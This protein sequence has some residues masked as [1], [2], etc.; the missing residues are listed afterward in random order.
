MVYFKD[1]NG[2]YQHVNRAL[3]RASLQPGDH[4]VGMTDEDI[5]PAELAAQL[6]QQDL[7][8]IGR[9]EGEDPLEFEGWDALFGNAPRYFNTRKLQ[10]RDREGGVIGTLGITRDD[11]HLKQVKQALSYSQ[12][13]I[14]LS[15]DMMALFDHAG[16][17]LS[18]NRA[19]RQGFLKPSDEIIGKHWKE[20]GQEQAENHPEFE[21]NYIKSLA[22]EIITTSMSLD[23]P[24]LGQCHVNLRYTPFRVDSGEING[25]S[26]TIHDITELD[27]A[28]EGLRRYKKILSATHDL[29]SFVTLDYTFAAVNAAFELFFGFSKNEIIG[30]SIAQFRRDGETFADVKRYYDQCI[31]GDVLEFEQEI[32]SSVTGDTHV[33]E[34]SYY[35]YRDENG[36]ITGVVVSAR[37]VTSRRKTE[38]DLSQYKDI[39]SASLD[40]MAML[41]LDYR[42][43]AINKR[44][45]LYF[46]V[47]ANEIVGKSVLELSG[48]PELF[49][50]VFKPA[51]DRCLSGEVVCYEQKVVHPTTGESDWAEMRY[52]PSRNDDG[53][54]VGIVIN[55][56]DMTEQKQSELKMK[57]LSQAVELSPSAV[58]ISDAE[59]LIEYVNPAFERTSGYESREVLGQTPFDIQIY[60][61]GDENYTGVVEKITSGL[62]W[63]GEVQSQKKTGEVY[64]ENV[65]FSPIRNDDGDISHY[66]AV[67]EDISLRR[68]QEEQLERQAYYDPLTDMP[69]RMLAFERL[70]QA[71]VRAN[72]SGCLVAVIFIDLDHFKNINDTLGH[73]CGDQLLI[74]A[75]SRLRHCVR[76]E[77]TVARLGGDE[78]LV[79]LTD[80]PRVESTQPVIDKIIDCFN[81]PFRL[82]S[83]ELHVT[84][85]V[86]ISVFPNDAKED[87]T[88]LRNADTA[89]YHAKAKGRNR[90]KFFTEEMDAEAHQRLRIETELRNALARNELFLEYQ[91]VVDGYNGHVVGFEALVRWQSNV[92][93]LVPPDKFIPVAEETGL[94]HDIGFWVLTEA[95]ATLKHFREQGYDRL[96]VA[97]NVSSKQFQDFA[98]V[99]LVKEVLHNSDIPAY[100]LA[101]E[102]TETLLLEERAEVTEI[103]HQLTKIG[104]QLSVDDFGTGYSSLSYLKK[105]PFNTLK[106]DRSFVKNIVDDVDD[107]NL[108]KAIIA[109]AHALHLEVIAEGVEDKVQLALLRAESCDY[110]QGYLFS[111]PVSAEALMEYI[112]EQTP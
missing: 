31:S 1:K 57:Q 108:T 46:G 78:F 4:F 2:V 67:K 22:G 85:S 47:P 83:N 21:E 27:K 84:A 82:G 29:M 56:R 59:G 106:I 91:P 98:L 28:M 8:L 79:L 37:D 72:R 5:F 102:V 3:E 100:C 111:R 39:V 30:T 41:D 49:Q 34:K 11:T 63:S 42:F 110:V 97:V 25:F 65:F 90:F 17:C 10:V 60:S 92:F 50:R 38:E 77:D 9:S 74:E 61:E 6:K 107:L 18:A 40:Y 71:M 14:D 23:L 12:T 35:P 69:N 32:I 64:W 93:G 96:R 19:F 15:S 86:G 24:G 80:L 43:T 36:D 48:D 45:E 75:S 94:I 51:Y 33:F 88:L 101:L 104:V 103:I 68:Q 73:G 99:D 112:Q 53:E 81:T 58:M 16:V 54:V 87:S 26:V 44:Y 70:R 76:N 55:V 109:M 20:I 13:I 105:Y 66:L 95:C 52:Y 89:M 62:S 7:E